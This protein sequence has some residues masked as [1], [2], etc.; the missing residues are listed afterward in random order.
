[1]SPEQAGGGRV[2]P[3]ADLWSLA[4]VLYECVSQTTPFDGDNY[5]QLISRIVVHPHTPLGDRV[6]AAPPGLCALIDRALQKEPAQRFANAEAMLAEVRRLLD[7]LPPDESLAPRD[8]PTSIFVPSPEALRYEAQETR[9]RPVVDAAAMMVGRGLPPPRGPSLPPAG[10]LPGPSV[11]PM[12][13]MRP[14]EAPRPSPRPPPPAPSAPS[15]PRVSVPPSPPA[16]VAPPPPR[17]SPPMAPS[18]RPVVSAEATQLN[19]A[20]SE[21]WHGPAVS[22]HAAESG[23]AVGLH[24]PPA[25]PP[26]RRRLVL[27]VAA[28]ATALLLVAALLFPSAPH[29]APSSASLS[30]SAADANAGSVGTVVIN[31]VVPVDPAP[32]APA[33]PQAPPGGEPIVQQMLAP[34]P[35]TPPPEPAAAPVFAPPSPVRRDPLTA[36]APRPSAPRPR[37][38]RVSTA[39]NERAGQPWTPS[40][41]FQVMRPHLPELRQCFAGTGG[42][43]QMLF[44]VDDRGRI[45]SPRILSLPPG[46][47]RWRCVLGVTRRVQ[48]GP[49][50]PGR[51]LTFFQSYSN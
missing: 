13:S 38:V 21:A 28:G 45:D 37:V 51:A 11:P 2:D 15:P 4:A 20:P 47:P 12:A 46:D 19:V 30:P 7:V 6:P 27:L 29:T 14:M 42:N 36:P 16:M 23:G 35:S 39:T 1:M 49:G 44:D 40:E 8:D 43:L 33:A 50:R 48:F 10:P 31:P 34:P 25:A 3:R 17:V 5:Q 9:T 32:P 41:I 18:L 26:E 22:A 24:P